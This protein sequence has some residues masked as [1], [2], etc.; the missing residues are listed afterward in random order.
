[1]M[2]KLV[3]LVLAL[4]MMLTMV[5]FSATAETTDE[6]VTLTIL[7][8]KNESA[9]Q[10]AFNEMF[11]NFSKQYPNVTFEMQSMTSDE[12][13]TTL[14]ARIASGDVP[15][16]VTWMKEIDASY[17]YDLTGQEFLNNLNSET[18]AGANAIYSEGTYAMP[19]DNGYIGMFYN[20]DVLA[21]NDVA[22]PTT[23]EELRA[24]CEA[25]KAKG[26]TPF[27]TGCLDLSVPYIG[28]I[29]LFAQTVYAQDPT[30]SAKRD[31]GEVSF[32]TS[33]EWRKAFDLLTEIVYGYADANNTFNMDYDQSAACLATGNAAFYI[34]GSW[35]LS[36]I[37]SANKDANIGICAIPVT[38]NADDAKLLAFPDTSM[39]V[40]KDSK[41]V[42]WALKFLDYMTSQEAGTIWSEKVAVSPAVKGV[43]FF[44]AGL[45]DG[46]RQSS[47]FQVRGDSFRDDVGQSAQRAGG[48]NHVFFNF[49]F[50]GSGNIDDFFTDSAHNSPLPDLAQQL[51]A[52]FFGFGLGVGHKALGSRK[53]GNAESAA[54]FRNIVIGAV[55]A[56]TRFGHSFEALDYAFVFRR[57]FQKHS[58]H[59][60]LGFVVDGFEIGDVSFFFQDARNF[61]FNFRKRD[62][63][64]FFL[65]HI[66][67]SYSG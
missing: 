29:G 8:L 27:A 49:H 1:M 32:A 63:H 10:E 57:V 34:Q 12:L 28:L 7:S 62:V 60:A 13:K 48:G 22:L 52:D 19:I 66:G 41:H 35:A 26:V 11:E 3:S 44:P 47:A 55:N 16:I 30:W 31:A 50:G 6:P 42:D 17:L 33:A 36:A 45:R 4:S 54:N 37:R 46:E 15:D 2:K 23:L 61:G 58:Y 38:D 64:F 21:A 53:N 59:A 40:M 18:V 65:F 67:V 25:L 20:K 9:P 14:R 24:A 56:G 5:A 39:S 51:A 43:E